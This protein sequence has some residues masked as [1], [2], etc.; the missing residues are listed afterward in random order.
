[1]AET[2]SSPSPRFDGQGS[3]STYQALSILS[4]VALV[5]G[6][7]FGFVV[8]LGS[9]TA[10]LGTT[11]FLLPFWA[12]VFPMV[13]VLAG[14]IALAQ[15][16]DSA[17]SLT[18]RRFAWIGINAAF[19]TGLVYV[20]YFMANNLAVRK[21]AEDFANQYFETVMKGQP[22]LS[23]LYMVKPAERPS[24]RD[25]E[26]LRPIL[27]VTYNTTQDPSQVGVFTQYQ[28]EMHFRLL[29]LFGDKATFKMIQAGFPDF[30][31][32][33]YIVAMLYEVQTEAMNLRLNLKVHSANTNKGREWYVIPKS[34]TNAER[35]LH[36]TGEKFV[37][38]SKAAV[39]AIEAFQKQMTRMKLG[40]PS[41]DPDF[42]GAFLSSFAGIGVSKSAN[43][44][45]N[46]A[47]IQ[48]RDAFFG[49]ADGKPGRF[50]N[51]IGKSFYSDVNL[52]ASFEAEASKAFTVGSGYYPYIPIWFS[53]TTDF[54]LPFLRE[55]D[56]YLEFTTDCMIGF[57]PRTMINAKLTLRTSPNADPTKPESWR[58]SGLEL[59]RGRNQPKPPDQK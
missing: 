27:E 31:E 32:G 53:A 39:K 29:T 47:F 1:M 26:R 19:V 37:D 42:D 40:S 35:T 33:G 6:S 45:Q 28:M 5:V 15:I 49:P 13:A 3:E 11:P 59:I 14:W 24:T 36:P 56:G 22:E 16:R 41:A 18:G 17:G 8:I 58:V 50:L 34:I 57:I 51:P 9:L 10:F 52:R 43:E 44:A 48:K 46:A 20:T 21:Q 7:V 54:A 30:V 4:V 38:Q 55:K 12:A 2:V 23:F 25:I